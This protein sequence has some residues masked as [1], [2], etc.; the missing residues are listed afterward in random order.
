[1]KNPLWTLAAVVL[2][3]LG[4]AIVGGLV[5]IRLYGVRHDSLGTNILRT[6][7]IELTDG[8]GNLRA[9]MGLESNGDVVL[10]MLSPDS[11]PMVSFGVLAKTTE[12]QGIAEASTGLPVDIYPAPFLQMNDRTGRE[13]IN[14]E[15]A[16]N[17]CGRLSFGAGETTGKV[18]V[19]F[20]QTRTFTMALT[21]MVIGGSSCMGAAQTVSPCTLELQCAPR[22][23]LINPISFRTHRT[24]SA[25]MT[26]STTSA[27]G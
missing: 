6:Q 14:L 24:D 5:A 19:G 3:S 2:L 18:Q 7:R 9:F 23:E 8:K 17:G 12:R 16:T 22:T 20:F 27:P 10:R 21:S 26:P 25:G 1:M 4:S 13:S 11:T 15:T